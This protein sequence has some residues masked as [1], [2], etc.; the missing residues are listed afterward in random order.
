MLELTYEDSRNFIIQ[1]KLLGHKNTEEGDLWIPEVNSNWNLKSLPPCI[2]DASSLEEPIL[3]V[4]G[5]ESETHEKQDN[6]P[7]SK[8]S[9]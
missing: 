6:N 5:G 7:E 4:S 9:S 3:Y 2:Q 1:H 8:E